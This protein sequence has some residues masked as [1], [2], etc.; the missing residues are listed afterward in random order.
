MDLILKRFRDAA[1]KFPKYFAISM[2]LSLFL[3]ILNA[4]I[5]WGIKEFLAKI[6]DKNN[7]H[8]IVVG[9]IFFALF[10]GVRMLVN[11]AWYVSLDQFGGRYIE[12]LTISLEEA[13]AKTYYDKIEN[14]QPSIIRNIMYTDV[15]NVFRTIGHHIPSIIG[16]LAVVFVSL[17]VSFFFDINMT[18]FICVSI[19][20]GLFLSWC[21][22][23]VLAK[24]AGQTNMVLKKHDQW[25]TQFV[26]MLQVVQNNPIYNYYAKRTSDN[27][28]EFIRTSV[29]E[30]TRSVFWNGL[31][32]GYNRLFS[33]ALSAILAIPVAGNSIS[34]LVFFTMIADLIME[35]SQSV[36]Q[37]FQQIVKTQ[38]SFENVEQVI[39]LPEAGGRKTISQINEIKFNNVSFSYMESYKVLDDVCCTLKKGEIIRLEGDNGS[40]KSTF[41]KLLAGMYSPSSG[42]IVI[43]GNSILEL[44]HESLKKKIMYIN[45]EEKCL[46]ETFRRYLETMIHRVIPD[47]VYDELIEF[48]DL[49]NDQRIIKGNGSSLSVG[50]RKKLYA[51]R[52]FLQ[53]DQADVIIL[54]ELTAGL[55]LNTK[56]KVYSRLLDMVNEQKK[57]LI[58]VDHTPLKLVPFTKIFHFEAGR[59]TI[60]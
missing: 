36:E 56:E 22:R 43:D 18:L 41:L 49:P 42:S 26:D 32:S 50:Q 14:M 54:D 15:L 52:L 48:V 58:L 19:G 55:D 47:Q 29:K 53:F 34:N 31:V 51:M 44:D 1:G 5:P 11:M 37:L 21:S 27:L 2:G 30:D 46:N 17:I 60:K 7:Y 38:I 45:Q 16:S 33:I 3:A 6:T 8:T 12:D 25:C 9:M 4:A 39:L 59:L 35:H 13:L 28:N 24:T 20:I 40:G 10:F 57:I 23:A